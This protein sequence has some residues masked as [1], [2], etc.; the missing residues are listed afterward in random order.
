MSI[1]ENARFL[2]DVRCEDEGGNPAVVLGKG[3][4]AQRRQISEHEKHTV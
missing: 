3:G 1:K 4:K 2:R